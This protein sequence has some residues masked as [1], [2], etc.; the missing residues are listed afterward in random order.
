MS[1]N[2]LN[3]APKF[4]E[5]T[6]MISHTLRL[7]NANVG[8][9]C[10]TNIQQFGYFFQILDKFS[11][12]IVRQLCWIHQHWNRLISHFYKLPVK[13]KTG[14]RDISLPWIHWFNFIYKVPANHSTKYWKKIT[15]GT[16]LILLG[17]FLKE[18]DSRYSITLV[19][20]E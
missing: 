4:L 20:F 3:L 8:N 18:I 5:M 10:K 7:D 13:Q 17:N 16:S 12:N 14:Y 15:I 1:Q 19:F 2:S 9:F 11:L 6:H